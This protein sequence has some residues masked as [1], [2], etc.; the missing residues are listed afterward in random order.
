M[1]VSP[2]AERY[3]MGSNHDIRTTNDKFLKFK[4]ICCVQQIAIVYGLCTVHLFRRKSVLKKLLKLNTKLLNF[5]VSTVLQ[6]PILYCH[7]NVAE[8][9]S[10]PSARRVARQR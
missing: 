5:V 3:V 2:D 9:P 6:E 8:F 7:G 10:S 4:I 1:A